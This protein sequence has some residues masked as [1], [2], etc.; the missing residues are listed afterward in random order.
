MNCL[1]KIVAF[2]LVMC[3]PFLSYAESSNRSES[4]YLKLKNEDAALFGSLIEYRRGEYFF[5]TVPNESG[6]LCIS[7]RSAVTT[8]DLSAKKLVEVIN[9]Y[10]LETVYAFRSLNI[11]C[12]DIPLLNYGVSATGGAD[13]LDDYQK[14]IAAFS[15]WQKSGNSDDFTVFASAEKQLCYRKNRFLNIYDFTSLKNGNASVTNV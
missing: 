10:G 7:R 8:Y 9:S 15:R 12:S 5:F 6:L 2:S 4:I 14:F 11:A 3:L 13:E 1:S